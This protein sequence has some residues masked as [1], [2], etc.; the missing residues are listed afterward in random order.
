M[1]VGRGVLLCRTVQAATLGTRSP[2]L[3]RAGVAWQEGDP[4]VSVFV[5]T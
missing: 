5:V 2:S 1:A 3:P 4:E